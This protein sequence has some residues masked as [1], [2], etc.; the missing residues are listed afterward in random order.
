MKIK[1]YKIIKYHNFFIFFIERKSYN[2]QL[3]VSLL[4]F[5][6]LSNI[7]CLSHLVQLFFRSLS[8]IILLSIFYFNLF[9]IF[10][11]IKTLC[12]TFYF[13]MFSLFIIPTFSLTRFL[14]LHMLFFLLIYSSFSNLQKIFLR[15]FSFFFTRSLPSA[16]IASSI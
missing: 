12:T 1:L 10:F 2:F 11:F 8:S 7:I 4:W 5:F 14:P 3:A 9:N 6:F 13:F 15:T 16:Y